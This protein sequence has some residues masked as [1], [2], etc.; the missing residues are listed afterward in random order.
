[1]EIISRCFEA[2]KNQW[3]SDGERMEQWLQGIGGAFELILLQ[4]YKKS[5][6]TFILFHH[7]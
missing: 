6:S 5:Y 3:R 2:Q 1:M 7:I 4:N